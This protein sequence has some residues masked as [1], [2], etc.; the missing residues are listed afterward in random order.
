[1]TVWQLE[2]AE[3]MLRIMVG[4]AVL[5]AVGSLQAGEASEAFW[6]FQNTFK[7]FLW[8]FTLALW[9]GFTAEDRI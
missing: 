7:I 9:C 4:G 2:K 8:K 1:M 6:Y 3:W 5:V